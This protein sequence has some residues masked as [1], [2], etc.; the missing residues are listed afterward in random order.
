VNRLRQRRLADHLR[1]H[2]VLPAHGRLRRWHEEQLLVAADRRRL[3]VLGRRFGQSAIVVLRLRQTV[4][5]V[6]L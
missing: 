3:A 6:L 5:L 4:R 1:R 2:R